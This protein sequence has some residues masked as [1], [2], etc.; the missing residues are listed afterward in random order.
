M[1]PDHYDLSLTLDPEREH[2]EG[3]VRIRFDAVE[4]LSAVSLD[5]ADGTIEQAWFETDGM[6]VG[7][8]I[9]AGDRTAT[10][11]PPDPLIPGRW[12][13]VCEYHAPVSEKPTGLYRTTHNGRSYLFTQNEP[14]FA[15]TMV[16]CV[17]APAAKATWAVEVAA[18]TTATVLANAP[19]VHTEAGRTGFAVTQPLPTFLLGLAVG[20]F[21][22]L[23]AREQPVPIAIWTAGPTGDAS[24]Y[25]D[26]L[27]E[28]LAIHAAYFDVAYPFEKLDVVVIPERAESSAAQPGLLFLHDREVFAGPSATHAERLAI[29]ELASHELC[30]MWIGDL[31]TWESWRDVWLGEGVVTHRACAAVAELPDGAGIWDLVAERTDRAL[32][33]DRLVPGG[34]LDS[35]SDDPDVAIAAFDSVARQRAA[36]LVHAAETSAGRDAG[37]DAYRAWI[38]AHAGGTSTAAKLCTRLGIDPA[39][40]PPSPAAIVDEYVRVVADGTDPVRLLDLCAAGEAAEVARIVGVLATAV[41][42]REASGLRAWLAGRLPGPPDHTPPEL[43][44]AVLFAHDPETSTWIEGLD[45]EAITDRDRYPGDLG[46]A[47]LRCAGRLAGPGRFD[48]LERRAACEADPHERRHLEAALASTSLPELLA[49]ALARRSPAGLD[50]ALAGPLAQHAALEL[51]EHVDSWCEAAGAASLRLVLLTNAST[52]APAAPAGL[53]DRVLDCPALGFGER[54]A[55]RLT[56]LWRGAR[57]LARRAP[58][59]RRW[60]QEAA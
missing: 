8:R 29:L 37:R 35:G 16:P 51:L 15:R 48:E 36:A 60:L 28:L 45:L 5:L 30:H 3:V 25:V 7:A 24:W 6:R 38:A 40:S 43:E 12:H 59:V 2:F 23:A 50:A 46:Y 11:V 32:V 33:L 47:V 9:D 26:A 10:L 22:L 4:P 19:R 18:P 39:A 42:G 17:D 58:E 20:D 31:V 53:L 52:I 14:A 44:A 34:T 57:G 21:A 56:A 27:A 54:D 55:A 41:G 13:A 1:R 49:R